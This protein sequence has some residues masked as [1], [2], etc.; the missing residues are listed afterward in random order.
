MKTGTVKWFSGTKGYGMI[1]PDD[2]SADVVVFYPSIEGDGHKMLSQGQ[3]VSYEHASSAG[4][5]Q[6]TRVVLN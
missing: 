6:T 3:D 4:G 1:R 2:G 5:L